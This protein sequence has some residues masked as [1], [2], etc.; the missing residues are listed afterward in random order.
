[1]CPRATDGAQDTRV[2]G[3]SKGGQTRFTQQEPHA[4][5]RA[6]IT[7]TSLI[8]PS[9]QQQQQRVYKQSRFTRLQKAVPVPKTGTALTLT[10]ATVTTAF[11]QARLRCHQNASNET[12]Y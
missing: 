1:L 5:T 2:I 9:K 12:T 11:Y 10:T 7:V 8:K 3:L 4:Q 6:A